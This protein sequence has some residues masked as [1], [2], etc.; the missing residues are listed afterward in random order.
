VRLY[1]EYTD[2]GEIKSVGAGGSVKF[3]DGSRGI[4]GRRPGPDHHMLEL[5][6][7]DVKHERDVE[8]LRRLVETHRVVGHP[9]NPRL[10]RK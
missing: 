2:A 5:E 4:I 8:G 7:E 3:A 6:T 9:K 10:E 1:I